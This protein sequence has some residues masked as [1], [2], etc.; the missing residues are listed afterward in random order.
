MPR[1]GNQELAR[2]TVIAAGVGSAVTAAMADSWPSTAHP[3]VNME[4]LLLA[5]QWD[6]FRD[7]QEVTAER[8][9]RLVEEALADRGLLEPE[10][11]D[12]HYGTTTLQAYRRF[13]EELGLRDLAANGIPGRKS[14]GV[15]AEGRFT[16]TQPID[17]GART[18]VGGHVFNQRTMDMLRAAERLFGRPFGYTQGSY[19]EGED[20]TSAGTHDGGGAVDIDAV[21]L[22][23]QEREK[24][25]VALRS[26]GFAA[27]L[28]T[29]DQH[30]EWDFHLHGIAV[31]DTDLPEVAAE[32]VCAY[33]EGRNGLVS[34]L[35]DDGPAVE[36]V[37]WEEYRR[38]H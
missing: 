2:R 10:V 15:L 7:D 24:A 18:T 3:T 9:V 31:G 8:P 5:A 6:P 29:P 16:V 12:G 14:L 38:A 34:D 37:L 1:T 27:W 33:Y 17:L 11:V 35:P 22:S 13:Q 26:V 25:L 30:P 28:R 36:K 23:G 21:D 32:Q 19:A 20:G 4:Q